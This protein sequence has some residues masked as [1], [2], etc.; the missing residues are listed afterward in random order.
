MHRS[1]A[2]TAST[3]NLKNVNSEAQLNSIFMKMLSMRESMVD[4]A[5]STGI[6]WNGRHIPD[7]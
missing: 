4:T 7:A 3:V 1:N 5:Q 6:D 2:H